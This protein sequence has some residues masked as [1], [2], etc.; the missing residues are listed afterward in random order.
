MFPPIVA[1]RE[2]CCGRENIMS[3]NISSGARRTTILIFCGAIVVVAL[4]VA[5]VVLL[6]ERNRLKHADN[7]RRNYGALMADLTTLATSAQRYCRLPLRLGGGGG[8]FGGLTKAGMLTQYPTNFNG[9]YSILV[10]NR[11]SITLQG[12]G[13]E[14]NSHD[15]LLQISMEVR[16]D[17]F[18]IVSDNF[19]EGGGISANSFTREALAANRKILD[20]G[21]L[22]YYQLMLQDLVVLGERAQMF[23]RQSA[24]VGG[25]GGSF[26]KLDNIT[27]LSILPT[28]FIASY[29]IFSFNDT[30][31]VLRGTGKEKNMNGMSVQVKLEVTMQGFRVIPDST[32]NFSTLLPRLIEQRDPFADN[33]IRVDHGGVLGRLVNFA[34]SAQSYYRRPHS[35]GGGG[36]TF[37]DLDLQKLQGSQVPAEGT[38]SIISLSDSSLVLEG[39]GKERTPDGRMIKIRMLVLANGISVISDTTIA[40][41]IH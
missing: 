3:E 6:L 7:A 9:S 23:Y 13:V 12:I 17:T 36:A 11:D 33:A 8:T 26:R 22:R 20:D 18:F 30:S 29:E 39:V 16:P 31:I 38:F 28:N 25:G 40:V 1:T 15:S 41:S 34:S 21:F 5:V 2:K 10:Q 37:S 4:S 14:R 35:L 32:N 19:R 24:E 27:K